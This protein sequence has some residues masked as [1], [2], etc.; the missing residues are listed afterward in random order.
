M[1]KTKSKHDDVRPCP[2]CG[3][4][5]VRETR[6]RTI[7]YK[8][9][10]AE[11]DQPAWWCRNCDE[12]VLDSKDSTVAD[13]AFATLKARAEGVLDP[14]TIA[15]IRTRLKLTQRRAGKLLGGGA[16][17][18]QRYESGAV[19]VSQPMSNLLRLLDAQPALLARLTAKSM[20]VRQKRTAKRG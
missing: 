5:M 16:R 7:R 1:S 14:E 8:K 17:A 15:R 19:V 12:G 20:A 2:A 6:P 9:H 11:I 3:G 4:G 13:R 10:S 18:F